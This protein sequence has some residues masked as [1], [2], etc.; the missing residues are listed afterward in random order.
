MKIVLESVQSIQVSARHFEP[1]MYRNKYGEFDNGIEYQLIKT[2]ADKEHL[3]LS[4]STNF[5]DKLSDI[6]VGGLFPNVSS[7]NGFT[8][9]TSYFQEELIMCVQKAK[10]FPMAVNIFLATTP[11]LWFILVFCLGGAVSLISYMMIPFDLKNPRRNFIDFN[12]VVFLI[13][14]PMVIGSNLRHYPKMILCRLFYGYTILTTFFLWQILFCY[15]GRFMVMPVQ[16]HQISTVTEIAENDFR[17]M[18]SNEVL[19]M[20]SFDER[21]CYIWNNENYV[22]FKFCISFPV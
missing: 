18:G 3:K 9:A 1:F 6:V 2:I 12:Y 16:R 4:F 10:N 22:E 7:L 14:I 15:G 8:F 19:N 11:L 20:I 17:L 5:D 13:M 21:V